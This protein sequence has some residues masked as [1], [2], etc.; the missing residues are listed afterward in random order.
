[1]V[2]PLGG[3]RMADSLR[4]LEPEGR[5]LVLRFSAGQIRTVKVNRL[6]LGTPAVLGVASREYFEEQPATVAG[7]WT[8]PIDGRKTGARV[9]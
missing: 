7:S 3:D 2:H 1:M 8:P 9:N 6:L 4:S 5:L